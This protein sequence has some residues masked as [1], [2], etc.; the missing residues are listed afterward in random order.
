MKIKLASAVVFILLLN[1]CSKEPV[2][3]RQ[4]QSLPELAQST[5]EV[6]SVAQEVLFDGVIE[7]VNQA[8]VA[9]QTSGRVLELP[10]DVGD[11]VEKG[12]LIVRL[13][14]TE[15]RARVNS[16]QAALDAAQAQLTDARANFARNK[17]LLERKLIAKAAF[18]QS[19]AS[20]KS[21]D[22]QVKAATARLSE[23]NE[24]LAHTTIYAPY[25]GIVV[26]RA[27][28]VGETVAPGTPL[29][30]GLS[31]AHLRVQVDVPQQ[32]IGALRQHGMAR[33]QLG[34]QW[35]ETRELRIPPSAD[36]QSHSFKVLVTVP[37]GDYGVFPGTLVKIAFVSG[38]EERLLV[39]AAAVA[40]RGE[41][42]GIYVIKNQQLEFRYITLG[43][44]SPDNRYPVLSGAQAG[45]RVA[46]DPI[47]A[48]RVY[49][50]LTD[51]KSADKKLTGREE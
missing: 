2:P 12:T 17:E 34:K 9:A 18:D 43:K 1:A 8:T 44:L 14:D 38:E 7:A 48:A 42:N 50:E 4:A 47:V 41:V 24:G 15:Q 40:R 25:S 35:V 20:F 45:E 30:T 28:K 29:L 13:T 11:F 39:P 10:V 32:H 22:A 23:A 46:L 37:E 31:L 51:K 33:V 6:A 49:K 19:E 5:L 26:S 16:A 36:A 21:A 3:E 27:T